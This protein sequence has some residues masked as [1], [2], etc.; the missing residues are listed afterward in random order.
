V[1]EKAPLDDRLMTAYRPLR[2]VAGGDESPWPGTL[3]RAASGDTRVLVESRQFDAGWPGWTA[4]PD[5]HVLGALDLVR[6]A[7]GHD[8][9]VPVCVER[10]DAFVRRRQASGA[11]LSSGETVTLAVSIVRGFAELATARAP[12]SGRWWVTDAGRPLFACGAGG[13]AMALACA[14]LLRSLEAPAAAGVLDEAVRAVLAERPSRHELDALEQRLFAL[15]RPEPLALTVFGPRRA[16][17]VAA[18]APVDAASPRR[19]SAVAESDGEPRGLIASIARHIDADFGDALSRVAT[20]VWRRLRSARSGDR[21]KPWLLAG[22]L[23]V[24]IVTAGFVWPVGADEGVTAAS[25]ATSAPSGPTVEATPDEAP[26]E[27]AAEATERAEDAAVP[28]SDDL[29]TVADELLTARVECGGDA[30][31]L[32]TVAEDPSSTFPAGVVDMPRDAR[33]I[34]VVDEFGGVS[35][36]RV[37]PMGAAS[38]EQLVVLVRAG[39]KWL[40]RDV[41]DVESG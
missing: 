18:D 4:D 23:A 10:A 5:G 14:E 1:E 22:G 21:R 28:P 12:T 35:V 38:G 41:Y 36:L 17:T 25:P 33:A 40:I 19:R 15:A 13:D 8:V 34:S 29:V 11:P 32:A 27:A 3:V 7:D 2:R 20:D 6:R 9:V 26:S 39:E 37:E 24:A 16:R 30:D 31:C